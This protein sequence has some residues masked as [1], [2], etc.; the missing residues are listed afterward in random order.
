MGGETVGVTA[1]E[2]TEAGGRT[3]L[4]MEVTDAR[5]DR[6]SSACG[7]DELAPNM[8]PHQRRYD[9]GVTSLSSNEWLVYGPGPAGARELVFRF[10]SK[11]LG[12]Y[13]LRRVPKLSYLYFTAL[14]P[15]QDHDGP[16]EVIFLDSGGRE[17]KWKKQPGP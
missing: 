3:T 8:S 17:V 6:I 15:A 14:V 7:F 16:I 2:V 10:G 4:C 13:P 9:P 5:G 11:G 1:S 12:P